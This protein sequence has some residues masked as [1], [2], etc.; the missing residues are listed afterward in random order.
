[1]VAFEP[2]DNFGESISTSTDGLI[3]AVGVMK[4]DRN[5]KDSGESI[6]FSFND[7]WVYSTPTLA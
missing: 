5:G 4:S 1:M 7:M 6:V 2:N 3:V